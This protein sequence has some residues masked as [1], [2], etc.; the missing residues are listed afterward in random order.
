MGIGLILDIVLVLIV[1]AFVWG[2]ARRGFVRTAI[3]LVGWI[4]MLY[5][6]MSCSQ[7]IADGVYDRFL[8]DTVEAKTSEV[9]SASLSPSGG[10]VEEVWEQLPTFLTAGAELMGVSK[11]QVISSMTSA[12]GEGKTAVSQQMVRSVVAP[13]CK[14]ILRWIVVAAVFT[15]GMF[16]V[17]FVAAW[18]NR[19]LRFR[20]L[21]SLNRALGGLL[22][23]L[24]GVLAV[25]LLCIV[26]SLLFCIHPSGFGPVNE[27]MLRSSYAYGFFSRFGLFY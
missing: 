23:L 9:V 16:I 11:S 19:L 12:V 18:L 22:G 1:A 10:S 5:I 24:K 17:R 20:M 25:Y 21:G 4:L 14:G 3:E 2:S 7:P 8:S 27:E 26:L 13:L 6:A 15:L